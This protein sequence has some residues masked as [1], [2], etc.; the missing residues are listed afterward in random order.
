MVVHICNPS[1]LG[2]R[3]RKTRFEAGLSKN[4]ETHLQNKLKRNKRIMIGDWA[5]Y[6][7]LSSTSST[8][9]KPINIIIFIV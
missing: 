4:H 5:Q 9:K 8:A 2:G 3:G 7:A 6:E 1:Y